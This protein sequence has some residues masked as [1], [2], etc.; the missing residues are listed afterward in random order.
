MFKYID[1]CVETRQG[2]KCKDALINYRNTCQ[3]V[4]AQSLEDVI[5]HL[6]NTATARAEGARKEAQAL[7]LDVEDLEA[8]ASPEELMLSYVSGEKSKDRT[9]REVVT[10]WFKFL[11]ESHRNVLDVLRNNSRLESLYA[12]GASRAFNFCSAYKR[13]TEFRRLCDILRNHLSTLIKYKDQGGRD[14]TDLTVAASW[15]L[16]VEMRFEQ[17]RTACDLELWAEAFRS[18]EDIQ[19]LFAMSPKGTKPKASLWATY[20]AK[21]TQIFTR[22]GSRL[23]NAYAWYRLFM[24]SRLHNKALTPADISAMA[25]NVVLAALSILPY[26][27]VG[28]VH[29]QGSDATALAQERAIKMAGIL[30]VPVDRRD[31]RALLSRAT[32]IADI[33]RKGILG[34]VPAGV[35]AVFSALESDFD[36]LQLCKNLSPLLQTLPE[37]LAGDAPSPAAP[38]Q[39]LGLAV[40]VSS[41]EQVA[42]LR[43]VRQLGDVYS[44]VRVSRLSELAPFL[45]FGQAE[46]L[47]VDAVRHGYVNARFDHRHD[48]I[49]FASSEQETEKMSGHVAVMAKRLGRALMLM[50]GGVGDA[51]L[52]ARRAALVLQALESAGHENRR[53]LARKEIIEKRKEQAEQV[54]LERERE[55]EEQRAAAEALAREA[56]EKRLA[57]ERARREA[58]RIQQ[59]IEE[60]EQEELKAWLAS[61]G[62]KVGEGEKLDARIIN[63]EAASEQL[64]QQQELQRRLAKLARQMDHLERAKR[65]EEAPLLVAAHANR[66][67]EDEELHYKLQADVKAASA[68]AWERNIALKK[69]LACIAGDAESFMEAVRKRRAEEFAAIKAQRAAAA[70]RARAEKKMDRDLARKREFVRRCRMEIEEKRKAEEEESR[71]AEEE[72][73]TRELAEKQK[74]LD[75]LAQKQKQREAE[76]EAKARADRG[77]APPAPVGGGR[78]GYVPP[79]LRRSGGS[80]APPPAADG[81]LDIVPAPAAAAAADR[82]KEAPPARGGDER[83]SG[84]WRPNR[85]RDEDRP[86][87]GSSRPPAARSGSRW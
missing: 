39:D 50:H 20:Y 23:Y 7:E 14:R 46:R 35:K 83:P 19:G 34:L 60:R 53:A 43:M 78:G 28:D 73:R 72:K 11:W 25:S 55:L 44:V 1:L 47:I 42:I 31:G 30:N 51:A 18:V 26:D 62:K 52:E 75:E 56:E 71:K 58:E 6:I 45:G 70:E 48:T 59:E 61:R 2:R 64:K 36:P 8:E 15:E 67:H 40:Y 3:M 17:L 29:T 13:S 12:S 85:S 82:E 84:V 21:L 54:A 68:A 63:K 87:G 77:S 32:L 37:Q 38:V 74:K 76:I 41:L 81:P 79:H 5:K 10:P 24:F 33:E 4:N 49:H 65:E 57:A 69:E 9:D 86:S 16:Y 27:Q 22:S 66:L 80:A